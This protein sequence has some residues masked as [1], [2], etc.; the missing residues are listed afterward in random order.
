MSQT[1]I[2]QIIFYLATMFVPNA[3]TTFTISTGF[4]Y[5]NKIT[6]VR[7]VGRAWQATTDTGKNAGIWSASDLSVSVVENGTTNKTDLSEFLKVEELSN[8]KKNLLL[9]GRAVATSS[10]SSSI[11]FTQDKD[12]TFFKPVIITYSTK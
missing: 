5:D 4:N 6:W 9:G 10:T 3:A 8:H 1:P 2:L 12:G 11:A 7:Q